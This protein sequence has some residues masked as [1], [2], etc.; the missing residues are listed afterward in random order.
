M[1]DRVSGAVDT[2]RPYFERMAQDDELHEHV[3]NAYGSARKIYEELLGDR[4]ATGVARRVARDT[5]LQDELRKAVE[6]LRKAGGR[7][8]GNESH[9]GRNMTLLL[10]GITLGILFNP[11]TGPDT[12]RW[13]KDKILGPEQ[14]FEE[15]PTNE[16]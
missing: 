3:K 8:Q 16:Q 6:E 4:G 2:A 1:K 11:A 13:L 15:Y 12:R 5:D 14:P 10:A 9:T 7:V